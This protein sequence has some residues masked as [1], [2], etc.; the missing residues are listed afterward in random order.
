MIGDVTKC[1]H[2]NI[3]R[4]EMLLDLE[5]QNKFHTK[6]WIEPDNL[7]IRDSLKKNLKKCKN[8]AECRKYMREFVYVFEY[9]PSDM[10][11]HDRIMFKPNASRPKGFFAGGLPG[12][13][14]FHMEM[15]FHD[16]LPYRVVN[17]YPH[18][19]SLRV[20]EIRSRK[21]TRLSE[22]DRSGGSLEY[23]RDKNGIFS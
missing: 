14:K 1:I 23:T 22:F 17:M 16:L 5:N 19:P 8:I 9:N 21:I 13:S 11:D 6:I 10:R 3:S 4:E 15:T 12:G 18:I 20:M 7:I 2:V